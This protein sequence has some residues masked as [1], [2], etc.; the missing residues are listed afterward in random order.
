MRRRNKAE[1]LIWNNSNSHSS[2]WYPRKSGAKKEHEKENKDKQIIKKQNESHLGRPVKSF[3]HYFML[4]QS[5]RIWSPPHPSVPRLLYQ[6]VFLSLPHS[7][8]N[9]SS[10]HRPFSA[11][12][13]PKSLHLDVFPS[14]FTVGNLHFVPFWHFFISF[15]F[16]C[17][18]TVKSISCSRKNA[19]MLCLS[20]SPAV[21][22][23]P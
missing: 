5:Q 22:Y 2:V 10:P 1:R 13:F 17:Y 4:V 8:F 18:L 6:G 14:L 7:F 12:V 9:R 16:Y 23:L 11:A 19:P 3:L 21:H 20:W 15:Y